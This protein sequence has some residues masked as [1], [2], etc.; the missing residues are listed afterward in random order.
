MEFN[1]EFKD[2]LAWETISRDRI[3][4]KTIYIDMANG[5]HAAGILLSQ[6]VY[7]YMIPAR[8]GKSKLRVKRNDEMWIA[9][10]RDEWYDEVRVTGRQFDRV[11]KLLE[12]SGIIEK[13]VFK[14]AGAPRIHIRIIVSNFLEKWHSLVSEASK[15]IDKPKETKKKSVKKDNIDTTKPMCKKCGH[16]G[17]VEGERP[18][19]WLIDIPGKSFFPK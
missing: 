13:K 10:G 5:D 8:D 12:S 1:N 4:V 16:N 7:W 18:E 14:F 17:V 19:S 9:K 11:V 2:F 3:D 15:T 6:L